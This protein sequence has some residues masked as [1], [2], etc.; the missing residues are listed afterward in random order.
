VAACGVVL[1]L[2]GAVARGAVE[3]PLNVTLE[4]V[5]KSATAS[6]TSSVS[7]AVD[8]VMEELPRTRAA[9]GLKYNGYQ[10]FMNVLRTLP[11]LGAIALSGRKV[12]IRYAHDQPHE[13]GRRLVLVSDQPLFFLTGDPGKRRTGYELTIVELVVDEQGG[14]VGTMAGA[15]RVK[16][17]AD[18]VPVLDDFAE[19]PVRL[20]GRL[21]N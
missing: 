10:G 6:V 4:A 16:P 17:G 15:A 19:A 14:I 8:R 20:A 3:Y 9:D 21:R 13:K 2:W 12:D 1:L 11:P 18:G 7:V 5:A